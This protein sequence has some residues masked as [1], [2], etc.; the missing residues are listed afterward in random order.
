MSCTLYFIRWSTKGT[1]VF[2]QFLINDIDFTPLVLRVTFWNP[3]PELVT[4][5]VFI[6]YQPKIGGKFKRITHQK[7]INCNFLQNPLFEGKMLIT[8]RFDVTKR[9]VIAIIN[10]NIHL[11]FRDTKTEIWASSKWIIF[12]MIIKIEIMSLLAD[13]LNL[14]LANKS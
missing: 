11:M 9:S 8:Y 6:F 3:K 12:Y 5:I 4:K 2:W 13:T 14:S 1:I 10:H 7:V